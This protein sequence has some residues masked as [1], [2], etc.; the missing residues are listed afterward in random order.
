MD[1]N[2]LE[3]DYL[4]RAV[5]EKEEQVKD[6]ELKVEG[7]GQAFADLQQAVTRAV[8]ALKNLHDVVD[9]AD[10]RVLDIIETLEFGLDN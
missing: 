9:A 1:I 3:Y 2:S 4:N 7:L 6:L 10:Q 5:A 8:N